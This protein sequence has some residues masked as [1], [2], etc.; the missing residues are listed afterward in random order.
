[1]N[2]A[3]YLASRIYRGEEGEKRQASRPAV[4]IAMAGIAIGVAVMLLSVAVV[5]GFKQEVRGK[6]VGF[7]S[8]ITV[9]NQRVTS[10]YDSRPVVTDDSLM[11]LFANRSEVKHAQRFSLKAG[12]IKTQDAFQGMVLKGVGPEY[13]RRFLRR[14]LVEGECPQFSDSA[15]TNRVVISRL[16]ADKLRLKVGDKLDTY[17]LDEQVRARRLQVVGIYCTNFADYDRMMLFTDL[18]TVNRLNRW[19]PDQSSGM[20]VQVRDYNSLEETTFVLSDLLAERIDR[21][22]QRYIVLNVEQ[23]NPQMFAWLGI[24]D[25]NIWVILFLMVGVAGFTMISGLLIIIIERTSMI[26]LLKS[27]GAS[28]LLLRKLFLWLS[29]FLIGRGMAWGNAVA[30]LLILLQRQLGLFTLDAETYYMD[31]VPMALPWGYFLLINLGAFVASVLMLV[32]PSYLIARIHP[33]ASM[34]YE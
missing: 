16:L 10:A 11:A 23:L 7:S 21:Y 24:L 26:G 3:H 15:S 1:M 18:C 14:H 30:L 34:R 25:V 6:I 33:A 8:H 5:V 29:V 9:M 27:L 32:G 20:E 28:N 17:F 19:R 12:M 2:L 31:T 22:G 4:V 13:D